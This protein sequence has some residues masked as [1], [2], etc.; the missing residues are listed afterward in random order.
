[1]AGPPFGSGQREG[2]RSGA[3]VGNGSVMPGLELACLETTGQRRVRW[4]QSTRQGRKQL[5]RLV[6]RLAEGALIAVQA[7]VVAVPIV[8]ALV[9][10]RAQRIRPPEGDCLRAAGRHLERSRGHRGER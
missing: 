2:R 5:R 7:A 6:L 4:D 3:V 1:M 10:G 9:L 8:A